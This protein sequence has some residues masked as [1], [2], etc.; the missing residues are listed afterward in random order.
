MIVS[1]FYGRMFLRASLEKTK[2]K[3]EE[4]GVKE[5]RSEAGILS[6]EVR[7]NEVTFRYFF[8]RGDICYTCWIFFDY[9]EGEYELLKFF[10]KY[11]LSFG[12]NFWHMKGSLVELMPEEDCIVLT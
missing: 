5:V 9:F 3:L 1:L 11:F 2:T 6:L 10:N 8:N 7:I 4:F 12:D